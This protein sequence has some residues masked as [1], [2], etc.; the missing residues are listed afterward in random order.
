MSTD[1]RYDQRRFVIEESATLTGGKRTIFIETMSPGTSVP[2]H[3]HNRFSETFD[4]IK[5][6]IKV[7]RSDQADLEKIE[8]SAT[9]LKVGELKTVEPLLW[10]RYAVGDEVTTLRAI[11]T[12]GDLDFERLLKI[13]NELADDRELE[14][15]ADSTTLMAVVFDLADTHLLGPTK[16][17]LDDVLA[18][19]GEEVRAVKAQLLEKYDTEE[20]LKKLLAPAPVS[21]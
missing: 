4:L 21:V 17:M 20:A 15:Y 5:G 14:K 13:M 10:H 19:K 12:P 18:T 6:S 11:V 1:R 9:D 3:F 8:A 16:T 2:P 7:Y